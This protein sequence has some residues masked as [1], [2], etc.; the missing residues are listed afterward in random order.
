MSILTVG[1]DPG[2]TGAIAIL[3]D[4]K[5][6]TVWDIPTMLKG[7]GAVKY[8]TEPAAIYRF[9]RANLDPEYSVKALMERTSAM[10]GQGVAS[11]FSMGDTFGTLRACLACAGIPHEFVAAS[12]WKKHFGLG[13]D[14]EASRALAAKLFPEAELHLKKHHDRAESLLISRY[15]WE[16]EYA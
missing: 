12:K 15:L 8:E 9:L 13:T 1:I 3:Q 11:M 4:G 7:A 16:S 10:P 14:K 2:L 6:Q 5:Y